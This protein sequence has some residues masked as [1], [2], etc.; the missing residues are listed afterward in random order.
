MLTSAE[1]P[2]DCNSYWAQGGIIYK[3]KDDSPSL[4]SQ[5]IITAGKGTQPHASQEKPY[6]VVSEALPIPG[7]FPRLRFSLGLGQVNETAPRDPYVPCS[8]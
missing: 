8:W 6:Y 5:D 4:L 7:V 2:H 1:H 3:G